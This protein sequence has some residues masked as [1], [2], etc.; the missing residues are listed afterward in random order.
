MH[1]RICNGVTLLRLLSCAGYHTIKI[2]P[3]G[4]ILSHDGA[5]I[6]IKFNI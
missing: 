3:K 1:D 4:L 2:K 6:L 5:N